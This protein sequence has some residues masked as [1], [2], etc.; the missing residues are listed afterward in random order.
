MQGTDVTNPEE[1][2]QRGIVRFARLALDV[3]LQ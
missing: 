3:F 2:A 1:L